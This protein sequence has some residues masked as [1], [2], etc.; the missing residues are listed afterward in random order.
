VTGIIGDV[1]RVMMAFVR[2]RR[3]GAAV[4]IPLVAAAIAILSAVPPARAESEGITVVID[5]AKLVKL[6]E[7]IA[8]LVI[9]NP[10]IADATLQ[11]GGN[12]VL[13]GKGYGTTNLMALDRQG[14]VLLETTVYVEAPSDS[15]VV[16][17]GIERQSYSCAPQCERRIML[18]DADA[19][20]AAAMKQ[21]TDRNT[22][23]QGAGAR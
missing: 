6:P 16:Y 15:V 4:A 1:E 23:A 10:L 12:M 8:S 7:R 22:Q 14:K 13:T 21:T 20:F 3:F 9:G 5:R 11:A 18:G 2:Q 17:R 19:A